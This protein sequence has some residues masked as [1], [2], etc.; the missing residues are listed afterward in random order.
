[1][2]ELR[3]IITDVIENPDEVYIDT[4][5]TKYFLKKINEFYVNT[6][7][8]GESVKTAYLISKKSYQKFRER[9]WVRRL[10]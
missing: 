4:F 1:L 5:N 3:K 6:I 9:K 8:V 10:Y 2:E 7:V